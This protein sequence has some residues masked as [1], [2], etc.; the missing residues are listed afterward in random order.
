MEEGRLSH[1]PA[2]Y[3]KASSVLSLALQIFENYHS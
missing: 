3:P 1:K 2:V